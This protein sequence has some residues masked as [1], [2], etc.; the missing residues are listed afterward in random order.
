[1]AKFEG[2][3]K[4]FTKFIGAYARIKVMHIASKH[5]KVLGRCEECGST[6][7]GL[8]AAH[9]NGLERPVLISNILSSFIEGD[10]IKVDL[11]EFEERFV[12]AHTP[13]EKTIRI[14]CR[15]CH[16]AYDNLK[17]I[18][19]LNL[20]GKNKETSSDSETFDIEEGRLIE[21]LI[22]DKGMNKTKALNIAKTKSI[23]SLNHSNTIF[24]NINSAQDVWWL[25]PNNKKFETDLYFILNNDTKRILYFFKMP[26]GTIKNPESYFRQR[27]DNIK[28]NCSDIYMPVSHTKFEERGNYN[29]TQLLI[30]KVDY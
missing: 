3:I 6:S 19:E 26:A 5:K 9:V 1:M 13:I 11:N 25:E 23:T 10:I 30:E 2:T 12:D 24:S 27:N 17:Q 14:L 20:Q 4:E 28:Q 16:R 21:H 15:Q 18:H 29:F 7:K 22:K 8:E